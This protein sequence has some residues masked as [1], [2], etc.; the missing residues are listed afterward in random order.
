MGLIRL[1]AILVLTAECSIFSSPRNGHE[2]KMASQH[3]ATTSPGL[4]KTG[5]ETVPR[6]SPPTSWTIK[7]SAFYSISTCTAR[8]D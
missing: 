2:Y 6:P 5:A 3:F 1:A 8:T 7:Q 4:R